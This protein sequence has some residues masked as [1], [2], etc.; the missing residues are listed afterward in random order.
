MSQKA[1]TI[2][3]EKNQTSLLTEASNVLINFSFLGFIAFVFI[4]IINEPKLIF[5]FILLFNLFLGIALRIFIEIK[6][7]SEEH[8][9]SNWNKILFFYLKTLK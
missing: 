5:F 8:E 6:V 3:I 1:N 2:V 7:V 9:K 4:A